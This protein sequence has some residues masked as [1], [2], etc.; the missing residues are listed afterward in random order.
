MWLVPTQKKNV[1]GFKS[2]AECEVCEFLKLA[3]CIILIYAQ[4]PYPL[5]PD[6]PTWMSKHLKSSQYQEM[7]LLAALVK[8]VSSPSFIPHIKPIFRFDWLFF[9]IKSKT[10]SLPFN[11]TPPTQS[12]T[13]GTTVS[14]P[15][16]HS[17]SFFSSFSAVEPFYYTQTHTYVN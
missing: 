7:A 6:L 12:Q 11:F 13:T 15:D 8:N 2:K 14:L 16:N 5:P 1:E 3:G 9:Q 10:C 17:H 4:S